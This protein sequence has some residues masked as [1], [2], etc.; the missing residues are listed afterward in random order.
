MSLRSY[1]D[2]LCQYLV[3]SSIFIDFLGFW[4]LLV[5]ILN[6]LYNCLN[7]SEVV[8]HS[9]LNK[10]EII[11]GREKA[12]WSLS[13]WLWASLWLCRLKQIASHAIG[14]RQL[15]NR[16]RTNQNNTVIFQSLLFWS[17]NSFLLKQRYKNVLFCESSDLEII[18]KSRVAK[19]KWGWGY[20]G[21]I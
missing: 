6:C 15:Q 10:N 18:Y 20:R 19:L 17:C 8:M 5:T 11:T 2:F 4:H 3:F 9:N 13:W 1:K 14:R 16:V 21:I 7:S 12:T